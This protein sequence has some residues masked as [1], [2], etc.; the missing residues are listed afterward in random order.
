MLAAAS[1]VYLG[2]V[3]S[4][5]LGPQP[6]AAGGGL[7]DLADWFAGSPLTTWLTYPVL[8][9]TANVVMFVPAG[10]L[11]VL[12]TGPRRWWL[13]LLVG[14]ALSAG[15]EATQALALPERYPDPRDLAA[16]TLGATLAAALLA[17]LVRPRTPR[18]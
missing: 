17:A 1:V 9:F 7:R 5:T 10:V 13:A 8:E 4:L 2:W 12:W 15:I 14:L 18:R 11:W 16:N 3:A 6:E